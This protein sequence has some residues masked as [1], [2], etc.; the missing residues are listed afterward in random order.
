MADLDLNRSVRLRTRRTRIEPFARMFPLGCAIVRPLH[1]IAKPFVYYYLGSHLPRQ[2]E[3]L[4]FCPM[5]I[6]Y[7]YFP[8]ATPPPEALAVHGN[9]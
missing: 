5:E 6:K 9:L 8:A 3:I 7:P 2:K 1:L 4:F